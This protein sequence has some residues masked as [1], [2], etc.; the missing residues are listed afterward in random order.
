MSQAASAADGGT[1]SGR[2]G[3][4][5]SPAEI[6]V[7]LGVVAL[8]ALVLIETA[9]TQ[10]PAT[11]GAVGPRTFPFIIG[12]L[13]VVVGLALVVEVARGGRGQPAADEDVDLAAPSDWRAMGSIAVSFLAHVLLVVPAGW[14]VAGAVLFAGVAWALKAPPLRAAVI[15]VVLAAIVFVLFDQVLLVPLPAGPLEPVIPGG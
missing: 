14:P 5:S 13:L 1:S 8:G 3:W 10:S 6:A 9:R 4:L 11:S 2:A 15:G 12:S 7:A